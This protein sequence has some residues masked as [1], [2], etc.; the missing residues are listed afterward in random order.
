M[1]GKKENTLYILKFPLRHVGLVGVLFIKDSRAGDV[2]SRIES[3]DD[4]AARF[5]EVILHT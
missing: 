1:T 4:V 3:M 2:P 5:R